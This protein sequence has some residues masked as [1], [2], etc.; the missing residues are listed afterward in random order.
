MCHQH[1]AAPT[2]TDSVETSWRATG[3]GIPL[4]CCSPLGDGARDGLVVVIATDI[5]GI[6][7]FYR[8][9]AAVLAEAG[10]RV[11]VPDLF[12]RIG[13]AR[14]NSREAAF[15][16]RRYLDDARALD[17]LR[18]AI[19][20][21]RAEGPYAV[22]GFCLGG[23]LALLCAADQPD[24]ATVTYYAFPKELP[25]PTA[26]LTAPTDVAEHIRGPVLA[27][28]GRNDYIEADDIAELEARLMDAPARAE[29]HL[30]D[31]AGHSFLAGL[32]EDGAETAA[33]QDA[34]RRTLTFLRGAAAQERR[35]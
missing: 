11:V 23:T 15:E 7:P 26:P 1:T 4:W 2:V 27:F 8:H 30:Y 16:R 35:P 19:D 24:Q 22:V 9:L 31:D 33:A 5:Y 10:H 18:E 17:D 28:W 3:T 14:D 12:H 25:A 34:W 21:S 32:T 6:N 29:V 20:F 13:A